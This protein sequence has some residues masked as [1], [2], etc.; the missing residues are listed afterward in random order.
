MDFPKQFPGTQI[1]ALEQN[2]RSTQ[3]IL[4]VT[5]LVIAQA[6]ERYT[7]ELWSSRAGG[8][9]PQLITCEDEH[10]QVEF[11]VGRILAHQKQ[12]IPLAQQAVLFRASHH[13]IQLEGQLAKLGLQFVKYGGLKFVEAAH[14]KDLLSLLRLAENPRD[15]V[16]G[17][18]ALCLLPGVGPKKAE[19]LLRGLS[20]SDGRFDV[21]R[22]AKIPAKSK[23]VW[24]EFVSLMSWLASDGPGGDLRA[25]V[26]RA[27]KFYQPILE[28]NYDNPTQRMADLEELNQLAAQATDRATLLADLTVDPP[29]RGAEFRAG[30]DRDQT[31]TFEHAAFGQGFGMARR[32][33]LARHR[34]QDPVR[35]QPGRPR[36]AGRRT[37]HVLRG[38]DASRRLAVRLPPPPRGVV[39]RQHFVRP[40]LGDGVY[41]SCQLS[42]FITK[43]VK[44][45]FQSQRAGAFEA[46]EAAAPAAGSRKKVQSSKPS[47][48]STQR[49]PSKKNLR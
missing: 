31:L 26:R 4:E 41:E 36:A 11:V 18:R 35:T 37:P 3:P 49:G 43:S 10:E 45:A 13:S 47:T 5:N 23:D 32:L 29:V 9:R 38:V 48:S 46:P 25:Q 2:Y 16:A 28:Q 27:L 15:T 40:Q 24:P 12:G 44:A 19:D 33:R 42:R 22:E 8:V 39:L 21:W 20:A 7:K 14:V 6:S 30:E 17:A 1:V 34:R